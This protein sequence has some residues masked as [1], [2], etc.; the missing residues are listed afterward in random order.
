MVAFKARRNGMT[1]KTAG[2][3]I[4][5]T[6]KKSPCYHY[7]NYSNKMKQSKNL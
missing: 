6:L 4:I 7:K 5:S 1:T 2:G 3:A